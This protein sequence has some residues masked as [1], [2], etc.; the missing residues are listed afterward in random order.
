ME[1]ARHHFINGQHVV[2]VE[3]VNDALLSPTVRPVVGIT[4]HHGETEVVGVDGGG[5]ISHMAYLVVVIER[6][7]HVVDIVT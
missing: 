4:A 5:A 2:C 7:P 3:C 1:D 6:L